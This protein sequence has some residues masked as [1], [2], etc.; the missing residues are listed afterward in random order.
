MNAPIRLDAP[1]SA[2][3]GGDAAAPGFHRTCS[4]CGR[5][6]TAAKQHGDFCAGDCRKAWNNRRMTRGAEVY[7]LLMAWRYDRKV[8]GAVKAWTL[9]CR[10]ARG[11]REQDRREREGR[12]SWRP[13]PEVLARRPYLNAAVMQKG[14]D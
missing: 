11:F 9:L 1:P 3:Q 7:D 14:R 12:H 5:S 8:S 2:P 4:E 13:A 6:Y 10:M